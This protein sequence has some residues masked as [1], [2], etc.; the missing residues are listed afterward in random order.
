MSKILFNALHNNLALINH[1]TYKSDV[2]SLGMCLFYAA[3]L[4]Y[5]GVDSIRELND[6][7]EIKNVL[8]NYLRTRYSKKLILFILLMLQIEEKKRPNFIRLEEILNSY[9]IK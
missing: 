8:F 9:F 6:M 7:N 4:S 1:N 5:G 2:F 3:S